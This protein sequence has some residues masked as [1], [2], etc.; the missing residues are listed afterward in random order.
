MSSVGFDMPDMAEVVEFVKAW[1]A[2]CA[3][4]VHNRAGRVTG[5]AAFAGTVP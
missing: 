2:H 1:Y 4:L 5:A 3:Q